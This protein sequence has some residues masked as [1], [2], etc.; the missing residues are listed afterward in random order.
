MKK[1]RNVVTYLQLWF[2]RLKQ[3]NK[4]IL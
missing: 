4:T 2:I 1:R 3:K